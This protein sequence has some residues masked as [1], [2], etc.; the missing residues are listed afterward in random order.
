MEGTTEKRI[1]GAHLVVSLND[2]YENLENRE[3][4]VKLCLTRLQKG[5][6]SA[7]EYSELATRR[8]GERQELIGHDA[9]V[10]EAFDTVFPI[11]TL[12]SDSSDIINALGFLQRHIENGAITDQ[13]VV[14]EYNQYAEQY[15][16]LLTEN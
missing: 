14:D 8:S 1:R 5:L 12:E 10:A 7:E 6:L 11:R 9:D 16:K 15:K 13:E 3:H 4:A 2:T